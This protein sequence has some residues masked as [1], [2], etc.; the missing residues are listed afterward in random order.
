MLHV[1]ANSYQPLQEE[2][3][4]VVVASA[5]ARNE[6]QPAPVLTDMG[7][8]EIREF[9]VGDRACGDG[10]GRDLRAWWASC[11]PG[12]R[13]VV[14][15]TDPSTKAD[16]PPLARLLGHTVEDLTETDGVLRV[17]VRTKGTP[18]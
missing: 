8:N 11:P 2:S 17:T 12:T 9:S 1:S 15:M 14:S 13:T 10:V 3:A 5:P 7:N 6:T 4:P 18:A 16:V